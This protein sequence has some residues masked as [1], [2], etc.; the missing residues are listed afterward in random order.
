MHIKVGLVGLPNVGKSSFFNIL[1]NSSVRSENFP[2][3][4]IDPNSSLLIVENKRLD[5]LVEVDNPKNIVKPNMEIYDIAGLVK[6]ASKGEGLGNQFLAHIREVDIILHI[7]RFF[8]NSNILHVENKIDPVNDIETINLELRFKDLETLEKRLEKTNKLAKSG[9][10]D[11]KKEL[12]LLTDLINYLKESKDVRDYCKENCKKLDDK[13]LKIIKELQL[14][15]NKP[16]LYIGN[17]DES[18]NKDLIDDFFKRS[19]ISNNDIIFIPIK[20][21]SDIHEMSDEEKE[22]FKDEVDIW[23]NHIE[24]MADKICEKLNIITFY[25]SGSDETRGWYIYNNIYAPKAAGEIHSDFEK[26]FIKA[27]VCDFDTY[28]NSKK[29]NKNPIFRT[30]GK[31]YIIKNYEIVSF[32]V[33]C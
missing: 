3:C 31:E 1:T 19:N 6:G 32:K 15:T 30:E 23:N 22:D 18:G 16:V 24:N 12:T 5:K 9:N 20:L 4:T 8:S 33:G 10:A 13:D 14:L 28:Y 17:C 29:S 27:D 2:F 11:A 7:V 25:T 21:G 26:N